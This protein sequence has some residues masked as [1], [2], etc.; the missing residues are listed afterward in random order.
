MGLLQDLNCSSIF[1]EFEL[2]GEKLSKTIQIFCQKVISGSN[3]IFSDPGPGPGQKVRDP[4]ESESTILIRGSFSY[5][6]ALL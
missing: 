4:T 1:K 3:T 5:P 2:I 6:I